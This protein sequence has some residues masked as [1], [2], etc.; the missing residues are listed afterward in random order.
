MEWKE[1]SVIL[2][3]LAELISTDLKSGDAKW[4][5]AEQFLN[6]HSES[7][8]KLRDAASRK[9]LGFVTF[10]SRAELSE[11]DREFFGMTLTS[12]EVEAVKRQT[13]EDRWLISTLLPHMQYFRYV[14]SLLLSDARRAALEGDGA[15]ALANVVALLGVSRHC[16][17]PPFLVCLATAE[18]M[19]KQAHAAIREILTDHADLWTNAQLRDLAHTIAGTQIDWRQGIDAERAAFYDGMQRIYT[20]DGQGDGRLALRVSERQN[21]FE[22]LDSVISGPTGQSS[23]FSN[24]GIA[25]LTLPAANMVVASRKDMTDIYENFTSHA[26]EAIE[27]PLWKQPPSLVEDEVKA[28]LDQPLGKFRYIFI[29]LLLPAYDQLRNRIAALDG[30]RD[31]IFIGLALELYHREHDK[32]PTSLDELSPQWLPQ[33]PVDRITGRPLLYRIVEDRPVVYS[34]GVDGDDDSEQSPANDSIANRDSELPSPFEP[35][36]ASYTF[37]KDGDWVIWATVPN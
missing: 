17:E 11:K 13:I 33:L 29:Q 4:P 19:Q 32:W 3:P 30:E 37:K 12:E 14:A 31:G 26:L 16:Q 1:P 2:S 27:T 28:R 15:T 23:K 5:K 6:N 9:G 35:Q 10:T 34:V 22:L 24:I 36:G 8:A 20:D 18:V 25:M 21:L 7:I